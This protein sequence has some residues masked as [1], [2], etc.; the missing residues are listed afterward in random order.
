VNDTQGE[1]GLFPSLLVFGI[2]PRF[3]IIST[4]LPDQK[5]RMRILQ[6]AQAETNTIVAER[7]LVTA[8]RAQI[9]ASADRLY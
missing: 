3:P 6:V 1:D 5:E 4:N 2:I 9:P 8:L 7:R